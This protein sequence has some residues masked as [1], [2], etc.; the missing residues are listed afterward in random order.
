MG[1]AILTW[2]GVLPNIGYLVGLGDITNGPSS[3]ILQIHTIMRPFSESSGAYQC[4]DTLLHA[5][6]VI[7]EAGFEPRLFLCF[8]LPSDAATRPIAE[9]PRAEV[10]DVRLDPQREISALE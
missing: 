6:V 10:H 8:P 9:D 3:T 2:R 7:F 5:W 4:N 1:G